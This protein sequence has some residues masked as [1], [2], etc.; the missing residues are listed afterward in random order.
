[1][2]G[3]RERED[4]AA[5]LDVWDERWGREIWRRQSIQRLFVVHGNELRRL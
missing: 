5:F 3:L 4:E 2:P 1:M